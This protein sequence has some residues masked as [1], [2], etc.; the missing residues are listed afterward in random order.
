MSYFAQGHRQSSP[1]LHSKR[2]PAL[3]SSQSR[4]TLSPSSAVWFSRS[5]VKATGAAEEREAKR[6]YSLTWRFKTDNE[7][8][9]LGERRWS[10]GR[11]TVGWKDEHGHHP[12]LY[13]QRSW[14]HCATWRAGVASRVFSFQ[15]RDVHFINDSPFYH[16]IL[17]TMGE[18][19]RWPFSPLDDKSGLWKFTLKSN[20]GSFLGFLVAQVS[21][22]HDGKS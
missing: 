7:K 17:F 4:V 22:D 8:V 14:A 6:S 11:M 12:T 10:S 18:D 1:L 5:R 2:A 20:S 21:S 3:E 13:Y 19:Q 16:V 9:L 15:V